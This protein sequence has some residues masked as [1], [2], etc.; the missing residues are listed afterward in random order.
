VKALDSK[1]RAMPS[2]LRG[3]A[4]NAIKD[5]VNNVADEANKKL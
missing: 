1:P 3:D 2:S 5:G 4:K